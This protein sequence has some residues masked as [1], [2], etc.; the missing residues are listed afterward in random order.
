VKFR[1]K[2]VQR[3]GQISQ[4]YC[5]PIPTLLENPTKKYLIENSTPKILIDEE[6]KEKITL[7]VG[8][9]LT[10]IIGIRKAEAFDMSI[11]LGGKK[12]GNF[13][14]FIEKTD[15][16]RIQ[17]NTWITVQHPDLPFEVTEKI[18]GSSVTAYYNNKNYGIC[19][20]NF[21]IQVEDNSESVAVKIFESLKIR[22]KFESYGKNI[23]IQGE[24][25]GHGIQGTEN[26][27][28]IHF[29][30]FTSVFLILN[31]PGNI[32]KLP[33]EHT[34]KIF[35]VF[36][37]DTQRYALPSE[38]YDILKILGLFDFMVP[39]IF[40]TMKLGG[41]TSKEIVKMAEGFSV[42][43]IDTQREGLVFKSCELVEGKIVHF[44]AI[45]NK[46]LLK[47]EI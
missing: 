35:D 24:F 31:F 33:F 27:R 4:G 40:P 36:L 7:S 2:T 44:K 25:I 10:N 16:P 22:E 46:Y 23:A 1:I 37:I 47:N 38:R 32:Y 15:Q 8:A 41:K 43:K 12:K 34:L 18:E 28:K 39:V 42:L 6:T 29:L 26:S 30:F 5:I 3:R 19:T 17:N 11:N 9:D 21:E 14:S 13:P 45:S 20:R